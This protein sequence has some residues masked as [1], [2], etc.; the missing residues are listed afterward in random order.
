MIVESAKQPNRA[1]I[2]SRRRRYVMSA[3]H[4]RALKSARTPSATARGAPHASV[5]ELR[6]LD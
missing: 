6:Q 1:K 4:A 5:K 3:Y 2:R